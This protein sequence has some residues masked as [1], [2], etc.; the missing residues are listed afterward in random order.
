MNICAWKYY[1]LATK[2]EARTNWDKAISA[3]EKAINM[4]AENR[5]YTMASKVASKLAFLYLL[6]VDYRKAGKYQA[7]ALLYAHL[8]GD[9]R[10]LNILLK[11]IDMDSVEL[12][13]ELAI[14]Y[15]LVSRAKGDI[16]KTLKAHT[17]YDESLKLIALEPTFPAYIDLREL[18]QKSDISE[19]E[20]IIVANRPNIVGFAN[21]IRRFKWS[22]G[23][24][25]DTK[26]KLKIVPNFTS[27]NSILV[28]GLS[29]TECDVITDIEIKDII[30]NEY[31][32]LQIEN[33]AQQV[34]KNFTPKGTEYAWKI[35]S[36][37]KGETIES[38]YYL[39]P[40]IFR[41][42]I[43][44]ENGSIKLYRQYA[45]IIQEPDG[46]IKAKLTLRISRPEDIEYIIIEDII[47][48]QFDLLEIT[49][50]IFGMEREQP[51]IGTA[52]RYKIPGNNV[53]HDL[54]ITYSMTERKII[55]RQ[56]KKLVSGKKVH[57][58]GSL[59]IIAGNNNIKYWALKITNPRETKIFGV[60]AIIDVP[61][62]KSE[63]TS[64][65]GIIKEEEKETG[66]YIVWNIK[67]I[68]PEDSIILKGKMFSK[69]FTTITF[70]LILEGWKQKKSTVSYS[71]YNERVY[72]EEFNMEEK[73]L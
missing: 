60:K 56:T 40:R 9:T 52:L 32:V 17:I 5:N 8:D 6:K 28:S 30:P 29:N 50:M 26:N 14:T 18:S 23:E 49:P 43:I 22:D 44:N 51:A 70:D 12:L 55:Y 45:D 3:Y 57:L 20:D 48:E 63:I 73:D 58:I 7:K 61:S 39:R 72:I 64:D 69:T 11:D 37:K 24:N 62:K 19:F 46:E 15:D 21:S 47:P 66:K 10:R 68:E 35:S 4:F 13:P 67:E 71:K 34:S 59:D 25:I 53:K 41:T 16:R 1:R 65:F 31:Q 33:T 38:A 36:L 27:W 2:Y 54:T 42:I